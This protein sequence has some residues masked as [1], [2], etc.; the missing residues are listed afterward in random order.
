MTPGDRCQAGLWGRLGCLAASKFNKT[1]YVNKITP[2]LGLLVR[3]LHKHRRSALLFSPSRGYLPSCP[4]VQSVES[5]GAGP[6]FV[7]CH[8]EGSVLRPGLA[9]STLLCSVFFFSFNATVLQG[10]AAGDPQVE[11][12]SKRAEYVNVD[13]IVL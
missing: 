5:G 13:R 6:S 9:Q 1:T 4:S 11:S 8:L 12:P 2:W 7:P 3:A 10:L